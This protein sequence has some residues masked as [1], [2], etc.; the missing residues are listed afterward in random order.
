MKITYKDSG[1]DVA[2]GQRAVKLMKEQVRSTFT[3][4]V[5]GDIGAFGGLFKLGNYKS[6]VLVSGTDGVG[7]KLKL[8][9]QMDKHDTVG[10]DLVA[11]SVN[12]ILCQ[13]AKPLFFLDYIA[14]GVLKAEKVA[15]IVSGVAE[16]CRQSGAALLGGETAEMAGFYPGGEYDLAGFAVGIVEEEDI[17]DGSKIKPGDM[18][19]GLPSS[20]IHSNGYSLVRKIFEKDDLNAYVEPLGAGLGTVLLEPTKIY[21]DVVQAL[22]SKHRKSV[23]GIVHMTGGGFYE[24]IP[25]VL[26]GG[27]TAEVDLSSW[28][29]PPIFQLIESRG[30]EKKEMYSTFNMGIGMVLVIAADQHSDVER[31]LSL[32]DE[33][34]YTI[35]KITKGAVDTAAETAAQAAAEEKIILNGL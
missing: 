20:G 26:P 13:G 15:E 14:A 29:V 8:A 2:E 6:P 35:G 16:G 17:I 31:W 9:F 1:V 5:M 3:P 25:R 10:I 30:V 32:M 24:N 19:I 11:M 28:E 27:L 4:G 12:D 22:L 18:L 34:F 7:T 33:E 23:R 21:A